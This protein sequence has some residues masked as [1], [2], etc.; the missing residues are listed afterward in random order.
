MNIKTFKVFLDK[1]CHSK[2]KVFVGLAIVISLVY[3]QSFWFDFTGLD[4][5][6]LIVNKYHILSR[7]ENLPQLFKTNLLISESGIY[8]RPLVSLSFMFDAI[9]GG[10][11]AL[12]YHISN[13]FYH[14]TATFLFYLMLNLFL[15]NKILSFSFSLIFAVHPALTQAVVWIP[16]R[17]DTLLFIFLSLTLIC[18]KNFIDENTTST[19]KRLLFLFLSIGSF[20]LA[21]LTKENAFLI[22]PFLILYDFVVASLDRNKL[23]RILILSVYT[24]LLLIYIILRKRAETL[25]VDFERI[26]IPIQDYLKGV[27]NYFGKAIL[28]F[29]LRVITLPDGINI[30]LGLISI[31]MIGV[32]ALQG[33]KNLKMFLFGLIWFVL[34][35]IS[36]T[37]GLIGFTN[38]LDH[39]L[40]VPIWGLFLS[41]SQFKI[42]DKLKDPTKI[43]LVSFVFIVFVYINFNH[44]KK[45][46]DP[47]TFYTSAVEESPNS[48][49]TLRGLANVYHK[50]KDFEAAER[51]YKKS[52]EL[53][54][55]SVE[56]LTNLAINFSKKGELDS[57]EYYFLRAIKINPNNPNLLNNLGNLYLK[58][59]KFP[60]AEYYL[61]KA[62]EV[63]QNYFEAFNNLGVLYAMTKKDTLSYFNFRNAIESNPFF[64]EGYF[65]LALLFYNWGRLDSSRFYYKKAIENGF[66][67][68]NIL[69]D[70][71]R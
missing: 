22:L 36:G 56:T 46:K 7:I 50:M 14:I 21:L 40:Y 26:T 25:E 39:R 62:V 30:F 57:A 42:I 16:G 37:V 59:K 8:Y 64:A 10:K 63:R 17:N 31:A 27:V 33:I 35:L 20:F 48:F 61:K 13:V 69:T 60:E 55:N 47:L 19:S 29:D 12:V 5:F 1:I 49:F 4:D 28:P 65:N 43:I 24:I 71:L 11:E 52:F 32:F 68:E 9:V 15:N 38:F 66:P 2:I 44:S 70:K 51:Y 3:L 41:L 45:F 6:D 18:Y 58:K 53:N 23:K 67:V 54:P 34:F